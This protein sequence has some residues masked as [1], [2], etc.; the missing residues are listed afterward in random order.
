MPP[1]GSRVELL[2]E[3]IEGEW[4]VPILRGA[5]AMFDTN[6]RF[7]GAVR[8][9]G[10]GPVSSDVRGAAAPEGA[11]EGVPAGYD[12]VLACETARRAKSVFGFIP[13]ARKT[14]LIVG[15][16]LKGIEKATLRS[17]G[18]VVHPHVRN[19]HGIPER[20]R[21]CCGC[22]VGI[23]EEQGGARKPARPPQAGPARRAFCRSREPVG[24]RLRLQERVGIRLEESVSR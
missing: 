16:E 15:N 8:P 9:D 1:S 17:A 2:A 3:N 19:G 7:I 23:D 22:I 13:H 5:A 24:D 10:A 14:A 4:N 21:G 11:A 18:E 6:C 20:G 12:L